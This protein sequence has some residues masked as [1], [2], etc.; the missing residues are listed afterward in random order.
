MK[1]LEKATLGPLTLSNRI[2]MAPMT[3]SR[4]IGNIPNDLMATYYAQRASAGLIIT[5]GTSPSPNGLGYARIPGLYNEEQARGWRKVTDAVKAKGGKIFVQLMHTGRVSHPANFPPGAKLLAP[6]AIAAKG[7]MWTDQSGNQPMPIPAAMSSQEVE[8]AIQEF[9]HAAKLAIEVAGFDG[10]ELHAANGYLIDQFLNPGSNKREDIYGKDHTEFAVRIAQGVAKAIGAE[11]T[12]MRISP[13]G[14]FNDMEIFE[15]MDELYT[16]LA[17][18][19]SEIGLIYIHVID[20]GKGDVKQMV[21]KAFKGT[22]IL[23]TG[24]DVAKAEADLKAERGDLVAF[25]RAFIANPD[26]VKKVKNSTPLK[27]MDASKLYTPGAEGY[28]DYL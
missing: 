11:R 25:G 28:T 12:G 23:S 20:H 3:R 15:K 16:R 19:L 21:R 6:S 17:Q 10:V 13:Y 7:E 8:E 27:E 24:Y 4:A 5:E 18:R 1:L 2:V 9:V 14:T 26:F 22:Y